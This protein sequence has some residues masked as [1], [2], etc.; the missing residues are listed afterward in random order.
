MVVWRHT[1]LKHRLVLVQLL[2]LIACSSGGESA[3]VLSWTALTQR[4]DNSILLLSEIAGFRIYYGAETG[5]YL[6][7]IEINDHTARKI[8]AQ[9]AEDMGSS[10]N[11]VIDD[12]I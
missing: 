4:E 5:V 8:L 2:S 6:D 9:F 3:A 10:I 12:K 7:T 11:R 1:T